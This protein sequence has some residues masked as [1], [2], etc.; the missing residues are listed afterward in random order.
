M[1]QVTVTWRSFFLIFVVIISLYFN[2]KATIKVYAPWFAGLTFFITIMSY[3]L[4]VFY[5]WPANRW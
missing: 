5:I 1:K 2:V 4:A 3:L